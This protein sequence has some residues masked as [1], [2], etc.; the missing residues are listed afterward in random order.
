MN[1]VRIGL[2]GAGWMGKAHTVAFHNANMKIG[3]SPRCRCFCGASGTREAVVTL[4][5]EEYECVRLIDYNGLTQAECAER[6][7]TSRAT[8]QSLY[9]GARKKLARFLVEGTRLRVDGGHYQFS[10]NKESD[11][12]RIAVTYENGQVFQHFGHTEQFK[13][14]DIEK[15]EIKSSRVV[16][17]NGQGHGALA[18]FLQE[19]GIDTLICGGIG[20]GA[21]NAL[22][23]AGIRL[24]PGAEGDADEQVRSFIGGNLNY[25]PDTV[26]AHHEHGDDADLMV[27]QR[28]SLGSVEL[29][30]G[31]HVG[32]SYINGS[33]GNLLEA[34]AGT[35]GVH[36]DRYVRVRFLKSVRRVLR[37]REQRGGAGAGDRPGHFRGRGCCC[38]GAVGRGSGRGST[39]ARGKPK[40]HGARERIHRGRIRHDG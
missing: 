9:A 27:G 16:D 21:R 5:L 23:E 25:D 38:P 8:V 12:M 35:A 28:G 11:T 29:F 6:M 20:G 37:Q 3:A 24:F 10:G 39:A 34:C 19:A 17:T 31:V 7:E 2:I 4:S 33:V 13:I 26:C 22:S 14:Y 36:C 30:G 32:V 15:G 1:Q 18:G 40:G